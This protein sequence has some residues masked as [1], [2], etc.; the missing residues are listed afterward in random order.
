M[1]RHSIEHEFLV[2]YITRPLVHVL[3]VPCSLLVNAQG[4]GEA[5]TGYIQQIL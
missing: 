3:S 2:F 5:H 1:N 4:P